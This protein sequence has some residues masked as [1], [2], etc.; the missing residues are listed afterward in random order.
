MPLITFGKKGRK[1]AAK[2]INSGAI[3]SSTPEMQ[4]A[5]LSVSNLEGKRL[6]LVQFAGL[7]TES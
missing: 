1:G 6:H 5:K 3:N 4:A 7:T 2:S